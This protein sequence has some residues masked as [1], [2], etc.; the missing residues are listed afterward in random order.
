MLEYNDKWTTQDYVLGRNPKDRT[1][2]AWY[3]M[4][5]WNLRHTR[6]NFEAN[7]YM[8]LCLEPENEIHIIFE[9]KKTKELRL[10]MFDKKFLV[11][12]KK[13]ALRKLINTSREIIRVNLGKY[14]YLVKKLREKIN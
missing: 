14:L 1:G 12:N 9:C 8:P 2:M 13:I 7:K 3:K 11:I 10:K 4:G 6:K 5:V